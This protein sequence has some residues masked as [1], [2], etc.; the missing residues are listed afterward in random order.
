MIESVAS[1]S[2]EVA[3]Y[4]VAFSW[5]LFAVGFAI[6]KRSPRQAVRVRMPA[7][8]WG[9]VIQMVGYA[10]VWFFQRRR[11]TSFLP[12][13]PAGDVVLA[14]IVVIL[15]FGSLW[16]I[17]SAVRMLG[18]QW[19]LSAQLVEDHALVTEGPYRRVRHPI[20]SGLLGMLLATG[21]ALGRPLPMLG[22]VA[23]YL[24]GTV[25]RTRVE[26]GLLRQAFG[27]AFDQYSARVPAL[28]PSLR[29]Q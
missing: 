17:L 20:Y 8:L 23:L 3:L 18:R 21:F 12:W 25:I 22:G 24:A 9:I 13:G 10:C 19:S 16:L 11:Q 26:E 15:A 14:I 28:I 5:I 6:R 4:A 1:I 29:G 27:A 7:A 2:R